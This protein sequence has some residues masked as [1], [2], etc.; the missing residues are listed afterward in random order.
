MGH[1][2][3][4]IPA[5]QLSFLSRQERS[6]RHG[7]VIRS[8]RASDRSVWPRGERRA[9]RAPRRRR[10]GARQ[11]SLE[12]NAEQPRD[13]LAKPAMCSQSPRCEG[14]GSKRR[15]HPV[16]DPVD[17]CALVLESSSARDRSRCLP[18]STHAA[19]ILVRRAAF[20]AERSVRNTG[21]VTV[22]TAKTYASA[23][24]KV[25]FE[26]GARRWFRSAC[27]RR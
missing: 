21:E 4:P 11:Q 2:P 12:R 15:T 6:P 7:F 20:R 3:W 1:G 18:N 9:D 19:T 5:L 8:P 27:F 26:G 25:K 10:R 23:I 13:V 24:S 14:E 22:D 16:A 17:R